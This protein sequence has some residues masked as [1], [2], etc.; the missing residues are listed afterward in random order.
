MDYFITFLEGIVTFISPCL[1]PMLPIYVSYFAGQSQSDNKRT[2]IFN[3]L[4][5]VLGFTVVFVLLGAFA[6]RIG[7]VLIEHQTVV[8]VGGG[9]IIILFGL[10]FMEVLNIPFL[11]TTRQMNMNHSR[12]SFFSALLFGIVFSIGWTPCVGA[13]LGSAL[14][15]AASSGDTLKGILML[16]SF[17]LGLGIPFMVSAILIE[18][19][20]STFDFVKR[21]YRI[22]NRLSGGL[23]VLIGLLMATGLLGYF[24][25]LLTF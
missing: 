14:M 12:I 17:S 10:N 15:M 1:L 24:L 6:G 18:Q 4:G 3:A 25:S 20:K 5:F 19:L 8:N 22:I 16:L 7:S 13:F 23:L 21:H 11:N 9:I 2:A